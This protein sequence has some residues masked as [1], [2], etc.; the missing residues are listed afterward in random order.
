MRIVRM[1]RSELLI[2]RSRPLLASRIN[3]T[4]ALQSRVEW[5][6]LQVCVSIM[7]IQPFDVPATMWF[8]NAVKMVTQVDCLASCAACFAV[9]AGSASSVTGRRG[10]VGRMRLTGLG[11]EISTRTGW[12]SKREATNRRLGND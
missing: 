7:L 2:S 11:D 1:T 6:V 10:V 3:I 4:T 9:T 8:P 12:S 5:M